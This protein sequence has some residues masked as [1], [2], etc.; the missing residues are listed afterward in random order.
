MRKI[1][2]IA[3]FILVA[4]FGFATCAIAAPAKQEGRV[5]FLVETSSAMNAS[6]L[7]L[8]SSM[9]SIIDSGLD[10]QLEYGDTIGIWTYNDKL[11]TD[12]PMIM[13]RGEHVQ[14]IK[15]AVKEWMSR[16]KYVH[17]AQFSNVLPLLQTVIR[18]SQRLIVIWIS[19]GDDAISGT[20]FDKSINELQ[21][22]F[23]ADFHKQ[24][25]PFVTL[26]VVRKGAIVDFTVNPGDASLRIPEF[27]AKEAQERA[28]AKKAEDEA[29]AAEAAAVKTSK[30]P[31]IIRVGSP[32]SSE[33]KQT[34]GVKEAVVPSNTA[35]AVVSNAPVI[36]AAAPVA[37]Q[38]VQTPSNAPV[39]PTSASAPVAVVTNTITQTN[40]PVEKPPVDAVVVQTNVPA[41][42][43]VPS[44]NVSASVT[45]S[46]LVVTSAPTAAVVVTS[47]PTAVV[48]SA[49]PITTKP[50]ESPKSARIV[51][52][53]SGPGLNMTYILAAVVVLVLVIV[54]IIVLILMKSGGSK[55]PSFISQSM[56]RER[57][58]S[59]ASRPSSDNPVDHE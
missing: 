56:T 5:L 14:D 32:E 59:D 41:G 11:N 31:L 47:A 35:T 2:I 53:L 46:P 20:P 10:G 49:P 12:C 23:R 48:K 45:T 43:A 7:S 25:I 33:P 55:G 30:P 54:G 50:D 6:K 15:G 27:L 36:D 42:V 13:W 44:T 39:A 17:R 57:L 28:A 52:D 58:S 51:A 37:P 24:H 9:Q 19:N 21:K 38:I 40:K 16:Q 4:L 26:L 29:A 18:S 22:E 8:N 1:S 34:N 3:S